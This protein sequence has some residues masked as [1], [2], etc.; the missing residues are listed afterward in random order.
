MSDSLHYTYIAAQTDHGQRLDKFLSTQ[1]GELTRSRIQAL[2]AQKQV[3]EDGRTIEDSAYKVKSGSTYIIA[4]PPAAPTHIAAR[5]L[6]LSIIFEDDHLL[7]IDKPA[8]MTVHPAPGHQDDTLVNAL[9]AYCGDSLSGIGGVARPGIV[10]RLDKD[11]SGLLVI[12]KHDR[13]HQKLSEQLADHSM[14]RSYMAYV[15]GAPHPAQGTVEGNIG[16]SPKNRQKMAMM[17]TGGKHA[18]THYEV[19]KTFGGSHASRLSPRPTPPVASLV[20]CNLETGRTHQI[21]VHMTHLGH[22]LIGD[23][24]YGR[25]AGKAMDPEL[26]EFLRQF[27]RQ[28]LHAARIRFRHPETGMDCEYT[29]EIPQD[30]YALENILQ[31][32]K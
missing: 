23:P 9:L 13:A 4:V 25:Q 15:W 27:N 20:E 8:G 30:L 22:A 7:V 21:R 2:I 6:P 11:T 29:S 17:K 32:L 5:E 26:K 3:S 12:A 18:I 24:V 31:A 16:R 28:A 10:H 19:I 14:K 1:C